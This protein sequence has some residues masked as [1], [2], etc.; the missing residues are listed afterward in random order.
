MLLGIAK[1]SS[2]IETARARFFR[3]Q[4]NVYQFTIRNNDMFAK[5][6]SLVICAAISVL[7]S[8]STYNLASLDGAQ[9]TI[10]KDL[11]QLRVAISTLDWKGLF[12]D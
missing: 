11:R 6:R 2:H 4:V 10:F 9:R 12:F 7:L 3:I 1:L 5:T 8:R